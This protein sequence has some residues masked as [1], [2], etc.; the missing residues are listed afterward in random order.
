MVKESNLCLTLKPSG[1]SL[2]GHSG[3][4]LGYSFR[5]LEEFVGNT[6]WGKY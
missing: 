6:Y 5:G 2:V 4:K 1:I 3:K